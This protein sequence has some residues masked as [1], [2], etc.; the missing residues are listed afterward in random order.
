[1]CRPEPEAA[2]HGTK[3][4][5]RA[6]GRPGPLLKIF[7]S[8]LLFAI[9]G[10]T[11]KVALATGVGALEAIF[12]RGFI[13]LAGCV[14]VLVFGWRRPG[15]FTTAWDLKWW[16]L[17]RAIIG[18][19]GILGG[20]MAIELISLGDAS[21]LGFVAPC[22]SSV[23]AWL[24]LGER[25]APREILGVFGAACGIVLIARPPA[26]FG[27][28][29][30]PI[31][32]PGVGLALFGASCA[33]LVVVLLRH[34]AQQLEWPIVLLAQAVGQVALSYPTSLALGR[35]WV[36]PSWPVA[37]LAMVTGGICALAGQ[38]ALTTGLRG[39][40]V[41][42]ASALRTSNVLMAFTLQTFVTPDEVIQP[43]SLV[44]AAVVAGSCIVVALAK[45]GKKAAVALAS[46]D[47]AAA[48][49]P[50]I[51]IVGETSQRA[52][53]DPSIHGAGLAGGVGDGGR[54]EV[55]GENRDGALEARGEGEQPGLPD[56]R[57]E[58]TRR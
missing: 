49:G 45:A 18:Y 7:V 35:T 9:Q 31:S 13:Q 1:M 21:A 37:V 32:V 3:R 50:A 38:I 14:A 34:L 36:V 5:C 8:G 11:V 52:L 6:P 43:L 57:G 22:I 26:L 23:V 10:A 25:M 55:G 15:A 2:A 29:A 44:G 12:V 48:L 46:A 41:G 33:G 24:A 42:P 39:A 53:M 54:W 17:F 4:I 28:A 51:E 19:G 47:G 30:E 58:E 27:E 20:F 16:L 56:A 40:R